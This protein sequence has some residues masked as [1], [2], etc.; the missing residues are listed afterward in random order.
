M[1]DT[2]KKGDGIQY[3]VGVDDLLIAFKTTKETSTTDPVYE[4]QIYRLPNIKKMG[5][6]GNGKAVEI[7]G[8]SKLFA[9]VVQETQH[10]LS[11]T[12]IGMPINV[13]DKMTGNTIKKGVA[14]AKSKA[15]EFPEF[16]VGILANRSDDVK[17]VIWYPN[18]SLDPATTMDYET[19]EEVFKENDGS[20]AITANG[21][22][23][24]SILYSHFN[25]AR[26]IV[27]GLTYETFIAQ[28]VFSEAQLDTLTAPK[29]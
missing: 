16:A 20:L 26:E 25:S 8:S 12:H 7:Y 1:A 28:P 18:C 19:A 24:S 5:V 23:N 10:E 17:D 27:D 11:L 2:P 4:T 14:F 13:Y 3:D 9:K 15:H 6:K 21:L 29:A 22:R